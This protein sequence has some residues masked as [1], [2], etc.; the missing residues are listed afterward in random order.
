MRSIM[1]R[2]ATVGFAALMAAGA[3][4]GSALAQTR[5]KHSAAPYQSEYGDPALQSSQTAAHPGAP[6]V[7]NDQPSACFT[8]EGYGR[9]ASCDQAGD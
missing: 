3:L 5:Y 8:D 1:I 9:Y 6:A 2:T 7:V 4:S